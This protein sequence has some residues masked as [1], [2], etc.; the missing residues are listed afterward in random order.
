MAKVKIDP[1]TP[2]QA[3]MNAAKQLVHVTDD[4]GRKLGLR[5]LEFLEE[6]R[7]VEAVG[8]EL[9]ANSTYMGMISP[10]LYIAEIDG[11]PVAI[12]RNKMQV[13]AL[14]QRAGREGYAAAVEGIVKHFAGDQKNLEERIKNADGTPAS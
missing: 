11:E 5:R 9:A 8:P 7:I 1:E 14:I 4:K 6:F 10:L 12:P 2:S 3:V 13:D